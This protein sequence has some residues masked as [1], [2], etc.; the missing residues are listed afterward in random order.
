M[1][2][3]NIFALLG[4]ILIIWVLYRVV[5]GRPEAFSAK[6]LNK[7]LR[8]MGILALILITFVAFCIFLLRTSA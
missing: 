8:T 6:N 2:W 3:I 7:S 5:R 4:I 1:S